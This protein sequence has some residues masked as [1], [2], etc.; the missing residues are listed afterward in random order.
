MFLI[1]LFLVKERILEKPLLYLSNFFENPKDLYYDNL[2]EVRLRGNMLQWIKYFL[3]GVEQTASL[4]ASSLAEIL[5]LREKIECQI[6][7]AYGRR[8]NNGLQLLHN[9]L[10]KPFVTIEQVADICKVTYK[11]AND[12]VRKFCEDKILVEM[13]GR[14][15]NRLFVFESYLSIFDKR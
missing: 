5:V 13:T 14:S 2:S 8:A 7:E 12:L 10:Q 9:L 11:S 1:T 3:V 15:R 6:R 4:A